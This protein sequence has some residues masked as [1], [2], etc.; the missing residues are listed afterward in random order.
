MLNF[1]L[2]LATMV[3]ICSCQKC[4]LPT[5]GDLKGVIGN[6]LQESDGSST[7]TVNVMSFHPVCLAFDDVQ[8]RYR[9]VS[10]I[11]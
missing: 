4:T 5:S 9:A 10:V 7:P 3:G 2:V 1:V 11:V 6:I 8:D